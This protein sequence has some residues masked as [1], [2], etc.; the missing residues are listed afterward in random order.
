MGLDTFFERVEQ[1]ARETRYANNMNMK[2]KVFR[3]DKGRQAITYRGPMSWN[4]LSN[5][6]K[7]CNK[8]NTF[9]KQLIARITRIWDN[10]PV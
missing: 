9:K 6:L 2:V 8:F 5:A 7:N 1:G 4:K 3:T 10:H